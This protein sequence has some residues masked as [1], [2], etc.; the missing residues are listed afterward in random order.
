MSHRRQPQYV[1]PGISLFKGDLLKPIVAPLAVPS[2][3]LPESARV[4]FLIL[5]N[6]CHL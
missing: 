2:M 6:G 4:A 1:S 3:Q 5:Q